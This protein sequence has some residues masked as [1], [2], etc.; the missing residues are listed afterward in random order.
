MT[1]A[2]ARCRFGGASAADL[3]L[4]IEQWMHIAAD[5]ALV[6][7]VSSSDRFMMVAKRTLVDEPPQTPITDAVPVPAAP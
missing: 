2:V 6:A 4:L 7:F 5:M 3:R 1:H